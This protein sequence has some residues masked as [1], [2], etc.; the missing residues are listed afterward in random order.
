MIIIASTANLMASTLQHVLDSLGVVLWLAGFQPEWG[1][2]Q[3]ELADHK[4]ESGQKSNTILFSKCGSCRPIVICCGH[5]VGGALATLC[6]QWVTT[7]YCPWA[8]V[9]CVTYGSPRI[10]DPRFVSKYH[11]HM[12]LQLHFRVEKDGDPVTKMP[13]FQNYLHVGQK[14]TAVDGTVCVQRGQEATVSAGLR[15]CVMGHCSLV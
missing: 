14:V 11:E 6:A 7:T 10:G 13:S 4:T 9:M 3:G 12:P 5:S 15:V 1:R 8:R 2:Y